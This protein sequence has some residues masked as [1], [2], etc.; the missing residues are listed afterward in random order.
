MLS[1]KSCELIIV[2]DE[3]G[4]LY[5][6]LPKKAEF[7]HSSF[8]A[9]QGVA[10]AGS[11]KIE[12]GVITGISNVSGHYSPGPEAL[13]RI[14]DVLLKGKQSLPNKILFIDNDQLPHEY[15][16]SEI[17]KRALAGLNSFVNPVDKLIS[18]GVVEVL[19]KHNHLRNKFPNK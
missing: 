14:L 16:L 18:E 12:K 1:C 6:G 15:Q 19:L 5:A 8:F 17:A 9:G 11:I 4:R 10:S 7:H 3:Y 2:I 13:F